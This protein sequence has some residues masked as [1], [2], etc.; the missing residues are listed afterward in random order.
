[1]NIEYSGETDDNNPQT[2]SSKSDEI[3]TYFLPFVSAKHPQKYDP[4]N[5]PSIGEAVSQPLSLDVI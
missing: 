2:P 4:I 3:K 1:M 5:I